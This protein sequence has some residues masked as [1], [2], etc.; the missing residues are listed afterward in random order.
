MLKA[1][2]L[3]IIFVLCL[4]SC[5]QHT[6]A[7][8]FQPEDLVSLEFSNDVFVPDGKDRFLTNQVRLSAGAFSIGNDMYTPTDKTVDLP[9][10]DRPWDG[11]TYLEYQTK[12]E[13]AEDEYRK[14]SYRIGAVGDWSG[15]DKLQKWIHN[16]LGLGTDPSWDSMNEGEPTVDLIYEHKLQSPVHPLFGEGWVTDTYG[17][18]V[19]TVIDEIFLKTQVTKGLWKTLFMYVGMSGRAV[20]YNTHLDGRL[21]QDDVYTVDKEWFVASGWSG[22]AV[23][24]GDIYLGYKYLYQTRE[25]ETQSGRHSYGSLTI[26]YVL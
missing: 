12:E 13:L 2:T 8:K 9:D 5:G 11:Y 14:I 20:L 17:A 10:G 16:D 24:F 26:G 22:I 7:E 1:S 23:K 25:F 19:G 18:R 15:T 4:M 6:L 3:Y 21:F